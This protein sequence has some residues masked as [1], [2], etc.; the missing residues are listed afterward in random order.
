MSKSFGKLMSEGTQFFSAID[1]TLKTMSV[2]K[3]TLQAG[4][5]EHLEDEPVTITELASRC[6]LPADKLSRIVNF[7][8][9]EEILGLSADGRVEHTGCS[10][11]LPEFASMI[12]CMSLTMEAGADLYPALRNQITPYEERFGK[13]IFEHFADNPDAAAFFADFMQFGT[14][15]LENFI[16]T[17]H[18]FQPFQVAVDVGGSHGQLLFRL[19]AEYPGSRG[20]L[21]D[22]PEVIAQAAAGVAS[23]A[24]GERVEV[25]GGDFFVEVPAG[26]LYLLK[27]VLHDWDDE[28]CV[29]I[30][31]N[32]RA[33]INPGGRIAVID[34]LLPEV[35]TPSAAQSYDIAM[36]IMTTGRERKRSEFE[37]VFQAAGFRLDKLTGNPGAQVVMEAVP[38]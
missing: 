17:Q 11:C 21:F 5:I 18:R 33:A 20:I 37:A 31:K 14:R 3:L 29:A 32:L 26:D 34:H 2:L 25:V 38:V 19:L 16:F 28:E 6:G 22:L 23:A 9:A 1:R 35:P 10:R 24:Q 13:P 7:L 30:L 36:M 15:R 27:Q 12:L 8:A 4:I